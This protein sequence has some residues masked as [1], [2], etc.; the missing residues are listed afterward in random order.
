MRD[1]RTGALTQASY[2]LAQLSCTNSYL[3]KIQLIL[4]DCGVVEFSRYILGCPAR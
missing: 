3:L 1:Y 4:I 2:M